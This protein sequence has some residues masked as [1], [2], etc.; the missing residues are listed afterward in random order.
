MYNF[1]FVTLSNCRG[2]TVKVNRYFLEL[3][4]GFYQ[5]ILQSFGALD[6]LYFIYENTSLEDLEHLKQNI[7]SKHLKCDLLNHQS[8]P[9]LQAK[10][11]TLVELEILKAE[12][13]KEEKNFKDGIE[14]IKEIEDE[15]GSRNEY[16]SFQKCPFPCE[17][18][19]KNDR[20]ADELYAH[21]CLHHKEELDNNFSVGIESFVRKLKRKVTKICSYGC[22]NIEEYKTFALLQAHYRVVHTIDPTVCDHCGVSFGNA[23]KL[24]SHLVNIKRRSERVPCKQCNKTFS[25]KEILNYH[26]RTKHTEPDKYKC[27]ESNCQK[28]FGRSCDLDNHTR[29]VHKMLKPFKCD[30]CGKAMSKFPNLSD[31]RGQMH[32]EKYPS[33]HFYRELIAL[34]SHPFVRMEDCDLDKKLLFKNYRVRNDHQ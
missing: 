30:K 24:K 28:S 2:E 5:N 7:N 21:L 13:T 15:E 8:E 12:D 23:F 27:S 11:E 26:I 29:I 9:E 16:N 4:N 14:K 18:T 17:D 3:Y 34:G 33:I 32:G 22:P 31:H 1:V 6:E 10:G 25:G 20:S 19:S